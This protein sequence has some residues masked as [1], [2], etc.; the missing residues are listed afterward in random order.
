MG[1]YVVH[2]CAFLLLSI[3]VRRHPGEGN[4]QNE[5]FNGELACSSIGFAHGHHG[6]E[7]GCQA[8]MALV[9]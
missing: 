3:A 2:L 1:I 4:L 8:G 6:G 7:T 5:V 9:Q